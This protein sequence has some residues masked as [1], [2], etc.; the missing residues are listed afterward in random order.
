M[1]TAPR[2]RDPLRRTICWMCNRIASVAS[3]NASR[4]RALCAQPWIETHQQ[5]FAGK[6]RVGDLGHGVV[7]QGLRFHRHIALKH[8]DRQRTTVGTA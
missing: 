1:A 5:S 2:K 3:I 8:L 4:L 7:H 6:V